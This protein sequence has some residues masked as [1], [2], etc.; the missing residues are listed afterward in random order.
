[1]QTGTAPVQTSNTVPP[2]TT[3]YGKVKLRTLDDVDQRTAMYQ[4]MVQLRDAYRSDLG[5]D[6]TTGQDAIVQRIVCLQA[7]AEDAEAQYL[8]TGALDIAT[9]TTATNA[10]RRLL[11]DIGLERRQRDVTPSLAEYARSKATG[12]AK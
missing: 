7:W 12:G 11:A 10:L 2:A 1:M 3:R 9:H 8:Q 6:P 4:R 5:G